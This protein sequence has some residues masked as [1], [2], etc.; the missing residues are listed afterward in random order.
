M[1]ERRKR[2][3]VAF[4]GRVGLK[5]PGGSFRELPLR[6]IS[7]KGLYAFSEDEVPVGLE[8]EARIK[9]SGDVVLRMKAQ[10]VRSDGR[11]IGMVFEEMEPE[12]FQRLK[13]LV[14]LNAEDPDRI[15]D[16]LGKSMA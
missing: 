10:V 15:Q 13:R 2:T 16:E 6:D 1:E 7:L 14:E 5:M 9:L 3:R 4:R 12:V 11:G 8:C